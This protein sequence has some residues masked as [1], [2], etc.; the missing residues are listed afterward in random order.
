MSDATTRRA[1]AA[2]LAADLAPIQIEYDDALADLQSAIQLHLGRLHAARTSWGA[3][4]DEAMQLAG[5]HAASGV[6]N[7]AGVADREAAIM[8]DLAGSEAAGASLRAFPE[9]T[10]GRFHLNWP[11]PSTVEALRP[12]TTGG[13]R[14]PAR[15]V[16]ELAGEKAIEL[17]QAVRGLEP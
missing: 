14:F 2:Q 17:A 3:I 5:E 9:S 6:V 11:L 12:R 1:Q 16:A 8:T 13:A 15:T 10:G 7:L 4:H